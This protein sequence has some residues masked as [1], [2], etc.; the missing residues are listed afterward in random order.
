[1]ITFTY[2]IASMLLSLLG[3]ALPFGAVAG[4]LR[5]R[6]IRVLLTFVV[7]AWLLLT[8]SDAGLRRRFEQQQEALQNFVEM[9]KQDSEILKITPAQFETVSGKVYENGD[10]E[11]VLPSHRRGEYTQNLRK[12]QMSEASFSRSGNGEAYIG[13][14][15]F[16]VGGL[17]SYYGYVYCP[18]PSAVSDSYLSCREGND[19]G[20]WS[21]IRYDR[22]SR[23]WYIYKV[24]GPYYIE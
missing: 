3:N 1:M 8:P 10:G 5:R 24:S 21:S 23:N 15:T 17:R 9:S 2:P 7:S 18:Q 22:L 11:I 12:L 20:G 13:S 16:G 14:Q 4:A 19:S 6:F